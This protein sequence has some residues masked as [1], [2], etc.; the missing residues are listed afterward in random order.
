MIERAIIMRSGRPS[1]IHEDDIGI[2]LPKA[3]N[4]SVLGPNVPRPIRYMATLSLLQGRIYNKLY[5]AKAATRSTLERLQWVST[6]DEELQEWKDGLPMEIRP[7]NE[8]KV[9]KDFVIPVLMMHYGYLNALATIHRCSV[10][11]KSWNHGAEP[12]LNLEAMNEM[13]LNPRVFS[14][15]AITVGAARGVMSLLKQTEDHIDMSELNVIRY[16]PPLT[17][18]SPLTLSQNARL[19]PPFRMPHPLRQCPSKPP[20][21]TGSL[22]HRPH[23]KCRQFP[24][25]RC[26]HRREIPP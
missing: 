20:R 6:L 17:Y 8:M 2:D 24:G 19:L 1:I 5:S 22:R 10:H 3:G 18:I 23:E 11:Y 15:G 12:P 26:R 4:N 25:K 7:G 21:P 9:D 13:K 16:I 14:S